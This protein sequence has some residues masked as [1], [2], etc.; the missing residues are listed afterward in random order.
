MAWHQTIC[1]LPIKSKLVQVYLMT[2]GL[3]LLLG[4][5]F[6]LLILM[7]ASPTVL[8]LIGL[9]ELP[10]LWALAL[11][12][13][14]HARRGD[15]WSLGLQ[16]LSDRFWA[17]MDRL[18][19]QP[20]GFRTAARAQLWYEDRCHAWVLKGMTFFVLSLIYIF[21]IASPSRAGN[22]V[23]FFVTLGCLVG[24]P[25][26]LAS[27]LGSDLGLMYPA[28]SRQRGYMSFL[29]VRPILTGEMITAKYR[30]AA[31]CV[32]HIWFLVLVMTGSWLLLKGYAGDMAECSLLFFRAYPGWRGSMI[33]GLATVLVPIITWKQVTDSLVLGL[34][35]RKWLVDGSALGNLF[36]LMC[37]IAAGLWCGSHPE[38]LVRI[39][40]PLTW[41]AGVWVI[42]K[43]L[44]AFLAFWLALRR[45]LL[46]VEQVRGICALWA[47]LATVA[48]TLVHL[49]LPQ[50]G[51]LVPRT[52]ALV[53][54]LAVLPLAR[55]A[56]RPGA[57]L[58]SSSLIDAPRWQGLDWSP[59]GLCLC[60]AGGDHIGPGPLAQARAG[61]G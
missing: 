47:V 52:V 59:P 9:I 10:A 4:A 27:L 51:L 5:P 43:A 6:A 45:G 26:L 24:T 3:T 17:T 23:T 40:P 48:L 18:T 53:A 15:E 60:L 1:W 42:I 32:L 46:R 50:E 54:S 13:L 49:L 36:L 38:F 39:I 30:M 33:L 20:P 25:F 61:E 28:W 29:A 31:R 14:T 21:A 37:L 57:G 11:L 41:V 34:T 35:G 12:G 19:R 7:Q 55:F 56:S 16:G 58:E 44:L 8:T 2:I 22:K